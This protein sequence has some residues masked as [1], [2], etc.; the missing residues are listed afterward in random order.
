MTPQDSL[1]MSALIADGIKTGMTAYAISV[2]TKISQ[3][4]VSFRLDKLVEDGV[5]IESVTGKKT[6]YYAHDVFYDKEAMLKISEYIESIVETIYD[7]GEIPQDGIKIV[8][9]YISS[10]IEISG[11]TGDDE[12]SR[13]INDF[14]DMIEKFAVKRGYVIS[15]IKGWTEFKIKWM[16]LNDGKCGCDPENRKCPC[17]ECKDEVENNGSCLCSIFMRG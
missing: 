7:V 14:V 11:E 2:E 16:A 10:S 6:L 3:P 4:Q 8:M 15:N 5:V 1:I 9:G 13:L 12:E 17:G